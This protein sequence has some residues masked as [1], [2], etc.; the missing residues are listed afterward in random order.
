MTVR[1]TRNKQLDRWW[2]MANLMTPLTR[3]TNPKQKH[4]VHKEKTKHL[5]PQFHQSSSKKNNLGP[6]IMCAYFWWGVGSIS[7]GAGPF[8]R[9]G[10][11]MRII[12]LSRVFCSFLR[13]D[14]NSLPFLYFL[15][16]QFNRQWDHSWAPLKGWPNLGPIFYGQ[17]GNACLCFLNYKESSSTK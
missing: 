3:K 2:P 10:R 13:R 8:E 6:P 14:A 9:N 12:T 16:R 15:S 4:D 7:G 17:M 1:G 11:K 5:G